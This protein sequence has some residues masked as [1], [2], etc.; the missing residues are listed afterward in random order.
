MVSVCFPLA[1]TLLSLLC[2]IDGLCYQL[3]LSG[4]RRRSDEGLCPKHE[5]AALF[6]VPQSQPSPHHKGHKHTM[7]LRFPQGFKPGQPHAKVEFI[8]NQD[9][10]RRKCTVDAATSLRKART[11]KAEASIICDA[12]FSL[13]MYPVKPDVDLELPKMVVSS[14]ILHHVGQVVLSRRKTDAVGS[15]SYFA[16][17]LANP[18]SAIRPFVCRLC[19]TRCVYAITL[20][21]WT[22]A[23]RPNLSR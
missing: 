12:Y 23:T 22:S 8:I 9:E 2:F 14:D 19:N 4:A 17:E 6:F 13:I 1:F 11:S 16:H 18:A 20:P 21:A 15:S 7:K 10:A 3:L 5:V